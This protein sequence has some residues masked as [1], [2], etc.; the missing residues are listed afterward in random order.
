VAELAAE[1]PTRG[2]ELPLAVGAARLTARPLDRLLSVAPYRGREAAVAERLNAPLLAPGERAGHVLWMGLGLWFVEG[3]T[4]E[5]AERLAAEAAV[6][7][8]SDA[9]AGFSLA[10]GSA[11]AVLA[12]LVPLDLAPDVFPDGRVARPLLRHV[13]CALVRDG[14]A[15]DIVVP[16]SF[17]RTAHHELEAAMRAVAAR[18]LISG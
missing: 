6:T 18:G 5:L 14:E 12:R 7:D 15:F 16:R 4:P 2:L 1:A 3:A 9:W 8:Q 11:R 17:T 10:G 13:A